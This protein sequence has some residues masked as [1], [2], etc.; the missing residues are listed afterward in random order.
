MDFSIINIIGDNQL[1]VGFRYYF[2]YS[3]CCRVPGRPSK[4]RPRVRPRVGAH[5]SMGNKWKT[6]SETEAKKES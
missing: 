5:G 1:F 3:V 4:T 6:D 2:G